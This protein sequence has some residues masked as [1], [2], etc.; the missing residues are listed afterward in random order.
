MGLKV[1]KE[2]ATRAK[3]SVGKEEDASY[4]VCLK[5]FE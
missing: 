3:S 2:K 1:S 5:E 4:T